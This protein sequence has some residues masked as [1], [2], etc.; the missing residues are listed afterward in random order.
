M[1]KAAD[2]LAIT[3]PA[4][5][6]TMREIEDIL[7]VSLLEKD[8]RGIRVSHFGEV[9]LKHAGESL[10]A[11]QRG[12]DSL[13]QAL[14]SEGPPVRIGTLPTASAT[15]MPDA[16]AEFLAIGTGSQ[17]TIVSGE[18]RVLLNSLRLGELDLVVGR[19]AAPEY[20]TGLTFE[21]LYSEEVAIIVSPNHPLLARRNFTLGALA[22]YTVLMPTKNS[23]IRPFVDR[24]LLTN[25]IPDLPNTVETVSDSFGRAFVTRHNAIWF[26]SRG[27]V[28]DE[29][30]SGRLA[31][32]EIDMGET[33]GA[34][35]LTTPAAVEP[36]A[37]LALMKQTIRNHVAA[38]TALI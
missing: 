23:V 35:G 18:N 14:K 37:A 22:N 36:S 25:G 12:M 2:A 28:A 10:A 16:V 31:E 34:V 24:L 29:L 27:V 11:V 5:T 33:R 15:I 38:R 8:G 7:G 13:A 19:L 26:I 32:L 17:V 4:V 6:R 20:M 9:F 21:P 1:G 3:Q 30:Q